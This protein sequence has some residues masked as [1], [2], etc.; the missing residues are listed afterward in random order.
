MVLHAV[1][2]SALQWVWGS[3]WNSVLFQRMRSA[4]GS[5]SIVP[6]AL[7][8]YSALPE[9]EWLDAVVSQLPAVH[10]FGV[11][12]LESVLFHGCCSTRGSQSIVLAVCTAI[13]HGP[14]NS[15][16]H[17]YILGVLIGAV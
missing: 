9:C 13:P 3:I 1:V 15:A 11:T 4:R 8:W 17:Y 7:H 6:A 14:S 16:S 5:Q 12:V 2:S 10:R